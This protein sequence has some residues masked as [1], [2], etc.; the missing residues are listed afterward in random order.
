MTKRKEREKGNQ[1][2]AR[3]GRKMVS[4][5]KS[6]GDVDRSASKSN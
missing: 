2:E 4:G 1:K 3:M 5:R 6:R